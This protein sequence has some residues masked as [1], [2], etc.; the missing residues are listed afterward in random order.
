MRFNNGDLVEIHSTTDANLDGQFCK[1][2]GRTADFA[3]ASFFI[4]SL[5]RPVIDRDGF[6]HDAIQIIEHCLR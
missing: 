5:E 3:E 1:V 2:I 6:Q 4:V